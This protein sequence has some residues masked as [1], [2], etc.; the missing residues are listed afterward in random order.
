MVSDP[1]DIGV[2]QSQTAGVH[3]ATHAC[4]AVLL[5]LDLRGTFLRD[6]DIGTVTAIGKPKGKKE[7]KRMAFCLAAAGA[8]ERYAGFPVDGGDA[9]DRK[10]AK[11]NWKKGDFDRL[12]AAASLVL[13]LPG[14]WKSIEEVASALQGRPGEMALRGRTGDLYGDEVKRIVESHVPSTVAGQIDMIR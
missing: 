6:K 1:F 3:E 9:Q 12:S 7:R 2:R 14:I 8:A 11:K 4:F 10:D 13:E 5:G